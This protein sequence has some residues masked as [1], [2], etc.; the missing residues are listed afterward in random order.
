MNLGVNLQ[1][2]AGL[3]GHVEMRPARG[4]LLGAG[5]HRPWEYEAR[6]QR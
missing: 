2:Q 3:E 4:R 1:G 6:I 5:E